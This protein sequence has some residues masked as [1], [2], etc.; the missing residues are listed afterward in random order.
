MG[1][2]SGD[3]YTD[4]IGKWLQDKIKEDNQEVFKEIIDKIRRA[5][6]DGLA[7]L[8]SDQFAFLVPDYDDA[9]ALQY[10]KN[11]KVKTKRPEK[12]E[13]IQLILTPDGAISFN[14]MFGGSLVDGGL[15]IDFSAG[16][17]GLNLDVDAT[18]N[19]R[20]DYLM[21]LGLGLSGTRG[22]F[23]DTSGIND[24][25]E[26]L[27]LD[28]NL[29]L[30]PGSS[31][32]GTLG[33]LKMQFTDVNPDGGSGIHGHFGLDMADENGDG[34]WVL[35]EKLSLALHA[36]AYAQADLSAVVDTVAGEVLPSVS[37]TIHYGQQLADVTLSTSGGARFDS[38]SPKIVAGKCG[39]RRGKR[40]RQHPGRHLRHHVRDCPADEAGDGPP[41][42]GDQRGRHEAEVHRYR[43]P[44]PAGER[45]RQRQEG[46]AGHRQ[47]DRVPGDM[48]TR[49]PAAASSSSEISTSP[50]NSSRTPQRLAKAEDVRGTTSA[51]PH[52]AS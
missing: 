35:G 34:A 2:K 17:P 1:H 37:A 7:A 51:V 46:A 11:G 15:P 20:I 33:F 43:L 23:L 41:A 6:F 18:I 40:L 19:G 14:L 42:D 39:P 31:A 8:D 44:G 3:D 22:V 29:N 13:D 38:G 21:G 12:P 48:W 27:A 16:L 30:A 10:D 47:H 26:E 52:T 24:D 9:G 45:R 25:A 5:L 50:N 28:V 36:S 49:S 32:S 4:G